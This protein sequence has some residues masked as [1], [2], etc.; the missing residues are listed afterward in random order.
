MEKF[1]ETLYTV[2]NYTFI[3]R[4]VK[5]HVPKLKEFLHWFSDYQLRKKYIC[6]FETFA[7]IKSQILYSMHVKTRKLLER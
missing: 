7:K 1:C 2:E 3:S 6:I 5:L 4:T